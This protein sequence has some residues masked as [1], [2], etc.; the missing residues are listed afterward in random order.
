ML[1][2]FKQEKPEFITPPS[3][4]GLLL[5]H[6]Q[7]MIVAGHIQEDSQQIQVINHLQQLLENI[8]K[9]IEWNE[10]SLMSRFLSTTQKPLKGVYI[11]GEVGTGKSMV[12]DLFF[13]ACP[14]KAKRRVHFHAFMQ[15][16]H[17]YNY[18][19]RIKHEGDPLLSL[20]EKIS[21]STQL[22]CFDEFHVT[23]IADAMLLAR[24]FTRLFKNSVIVVSTS[25]QQPDELYKDGLQRELFLPFIALL[26]KHSDI[27][28]LNAK[29]DYRLLHFKSM[30]TTFYSEPSGGNE[31]LQQH[32]NE[33]SNGGKKT[34]RVLKFK[35]RELRFATV[36]GDILMTSFAELCQREL[37]PIDFLAIVKEFSTILLANIPE[38]SAEINDQARR[39]VTLIDEIYEHNVKLICTAA[40][41]AEQ[42]AIKDR[43]FDFK[44]TR[45]RLIEMQSEKYFQKKHIP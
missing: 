36:Y 23:D 15:E 17:D 33:L 31:F 13:N 7:E 41:P 34:S 4:Q 44:R 3:V 10:Q 12:M 14:I 5:K 25:N 22:L 28:A 32:F 9:Q 24:L 16:V 29:K 40:V 27:T 20:A 26:K 35:G 8:L 37:G 11:F 6:Y 45:S 18:Q 38:F 19:W 1:N 30:K 39:F 21:Q 43:S 42:L 2:L